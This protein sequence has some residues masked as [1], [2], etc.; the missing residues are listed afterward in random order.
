L[1]F[2]LLCKLVYNFFSIPPENKH[3]IRA[4]KLIPKRGVTV[5]N[6]LIKLVM[7]ISSSVGGDL[8]TPQF[9]GTNYDFW[10]IKMETILI[11]FDL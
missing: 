9:N 3:G 5:K 2:N 8:R 1:L 6:R 11:A 10:A 7:V 4:L